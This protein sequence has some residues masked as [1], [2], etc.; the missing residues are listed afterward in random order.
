MVRGNAPLSL[1]TLTKNPHPPP[2]GRGY[3]Q[4]EAA[5]SPAKSNAE[6]MIFY[7]ESVYT[8][9]AD[10]ADNSR[11]TATKRPRG[12]QKFDL[13]MKLIIYLANI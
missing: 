8:Q 13:M 9:Y 3:R 7:S 1:E 12:A 11:L 6:N 4:H 5:L 10:F 2:R